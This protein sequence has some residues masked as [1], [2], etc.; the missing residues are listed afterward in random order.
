MTEK[1]SPALESING[2]VIPLELEKLS[3]LKDALARKIL[4]QLIK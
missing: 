3:A 2:V 4:D 1:L